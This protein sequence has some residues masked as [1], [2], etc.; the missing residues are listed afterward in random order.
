MLI[1]LVGQKSHLATGVVR[2]IT[3]AK[4]H[5]IP[6]FGIYVGNAGITTGLP[7]GMMRSR[8]CNWKWNEIASWVDQC[9]KE[10]KNKS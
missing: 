7:E 9:M 4:E 1:V 3:F 5:N 10:E 6:V 8:V 2:E